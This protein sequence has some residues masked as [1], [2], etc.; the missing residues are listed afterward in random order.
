MK[1]SRSSSWRSSRRGSC[2]PDPH[3]SCP[4][5]IAC[6]RDDR[7]WYHV[8]QAGSPCSDRY[9]AVEPHYNGLARVKRSGGCGGWAVVDESGLVVAELGESVR[10]SAAHLEGVSKLY[11]QSLALKQILETD[12]L[13]GGCE[14][15]QRQVLRNV[16]VDMGLLKPPT[17]SAGDHTGD[18]CAGAD[19]LELLQRGELLGDCVT[20]ARCRYWLQ[21]R[22]LG[23]WLSDTACSASAS[24]AS[25]ASASS[26]SASSASASSASSASAS[27]ASASAP[28]AACAPQLDTFRSIA[29]DAVAVALSQRVL[30]SYAETDW[31]HI[32]EHLPRE[33]LRG[34][35]A[36]ADLGGGQGALLR[37]LAPLLP[38]PSVRLICLERPEVVQAAQA[39]SAEW[40]G[41]SFEPGDLFSGPLPAAD[42]YVMSRVLHDWDDTRAKKILRRVRS[43]CGS[44]SRLVVVDRAAGENLH[45]LL[46]LHMYHLQR[47]C[48]RTEAQWAELF[49]DT[50]WEV[51]QQTPLGEHLIYTLRAGAHG[52]TSCDPDISAARVAPTP[53]V[54]HVV[55]PTPRVAHVEAGSI[56]R[57]TKA[58]I[59]IAGLGSRMHPVSATTPKAF[60]PLFLDGRSGAAVVPALAVLLDQIFAPGGIERACVVASPA[61]LPQLHAF[62]GWYRP[63]L[64]A[65]QSV[66][67]AV[68]GS[69]RGMGD[70]C[71]AARQFV[72]ADAF[73][74]AVGDHVYSPGC[75]EQ[76]LRAHAALADHLSQAGQ[77]GQ[78][79]GQ[80]GAGDV[81]LTGACLCAESE[82]AATGLIAGQSPSPAVGEAFLVQ[83]MEEKPAAYAQFQL[84][85]HQGKYLSQLGL[86]ILP[87]SVFDALQEAL[88]TPSGELCLR[89]VVRDCLQAQ[90]RLYSVLVEGERHDI[91]TPAAYLDTLQRVYQASTLQGEHTADADTGGGARYMGV[92]GA[93]EGLLHAGGSR[94][95]A[96]VQHVLGAPTQAHV[97]SAPG[98]V[99][100][101]GGFADYSGS[102]AVVQTTAQRTAALATMTTPP[103]AGAG[104]LRL[105]T[106]QVRDLEASCPALISCRELTVPTSTLFH[107]GRLMQGAA[108]RD[109]LSRLVPQDECAWAYYLVG[110]IHQ[111]CAQSNVSMLPLLPHSDLSLVALSDLPWN[112]GLASSAAVTAAAALS[113]GRAMGLPE[114]LLA[115]RSTALL[116]QRVENDFVGAP[117]GILDQAG[118]TDPAAGAGL[119]GVD[120]SQRFSHPPTHGV[121]LP[122]GLAVVALESGVARCTRS[123]AYLQV[124]VAAEVGR[125]L[126]GDLLA[127]EVRELCEVAPSE[128]ASVSDHLPVAAT[129]AKLLTLMARSQAASP[130]LL[131][132][133]ATYPVRSATAHPIH[134][135]FRVVALEAALQ[136]PHTHS[137]AALD[138]LGELMR[139]SH[140]SYSLCGLGTEQTSLLVHLLTHTHSVDGSNRVVGAKLSGG[141]GG[142]AVVALVQNL[143]LPDAH[144]S[145]KA[146]SRQDCF[147]RRVQGQYEQRTGLSCVLRAGSSP[148]A[149]YYPNQHRAYSCK[150]PVN[151]PAPERPS[152]HD[153]LSPPG[154]PWPRR[155]LVVNHGYPPDFNGGSEVYAQTLALQLRKA[156]GPDSVR[157]FAR[158]CDPFRCDF[159]VRRGADPIDPGLPVYRMNYPREAPYFRFSAAP[160]DEAFRTVLEE[161]QPDV[162]H[163]HHLNHLSLGLP[164]VAKESG[165]AVVYTLHDYWLLCPRGQF[166]VTGVTA[167]ATE[168]GRPAEPWRQCGGQGDRKCAVSCY[169]G[170]YATG[171]GDGYGCTDRRGEV[172]GLPAKRPLAEVAPD[173]SLSLSLSAAEEDYWTRWI[174]Q[175]MAATRQACSHVDA[176]LA[177]SR[178]LFDKFEQQPDAIDAAKMRLMPYGFDRA[179]LS[180]RQRP[181]LES[182]AVTAPF[183]FAYIGRHLPA[184]G[185]NLLV[186][187]ALLL[188]G[189]PSFKQRFV[190]KIF[191]PQE[192]HSTRALRR[193]ADEVDEAPGSGRLQWEGEYANADIVPRVF[194]Q[195]DCIVVPSIWEENSPLVI[196]EALQS[197]VPVITA[198]SGGM[199]E[200][201]KDG[202]NGLT[203]EHRSAPSLAG[204][205]QRA[206]EQPRGLQTLA[207]RGY[208]HSEDGQVPCIAQHVEQMLQ[209]YRALL[210][211]TAQAAPDA[212]PDS[213]ITPLP[214]PWRVTFD[215]NP[216]DCNF[217][218]TMCE[219]HSEHSPHQRARRA[220][221][222]RRRRMDVRTIRS[223]VR[224]LAPRGLREIIPTTMGEPLQY[225][226]LPEMLDLCREF[227]VKLNLTTNGSF[228]GRGVDAW[229][230]LIVPVASDVKFSWN[231]ATR[232]TQERIMKGADFHKQV[233]NLQRFVAI[234]DGEAGAGNYCSVTLQLT[235]M[236]A[237]LCE[238]PALVRFAV[239]RGCDRVKGHHLWA[240][241]EQIADQ[242]LRR[243]AGSVARWNSTAALC[244][245]VAAENPLPSGKLLRLQNFHDL[246]VTGGLDPA[247]PAEPA[248]GVQGAQGAQGGGAC[249]FLGREAWVNWQGRFDPC[250]APD[251]ERKSLGYLGN[252]T[253][254]GQSVSEIWSS[255]QYRQLV[256]S[257]TAHPL[258]RTC[259]MRKPAD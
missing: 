181:A 107:D 188:G 229:A 46:S 238:L 166:S 157:V 104:T 176:F 240:H 217:H 231:G 57:V 77:A 216:D 186:Q 90:G 149:R 235:F 92:L 228:H 220:Q 136:A 131:D 86:D 105:A 191:G 223:V 190:V 101:M 141:G 256:S 227:G 225:A 35:T 98:R 143:R 221:G 158:E 34:V 259:T 164:G 72:G 219:Q 178:H 49:A 146:G 140:Q 44:D 230:R 56:P 145:S 212:H 197:G 134:E 208:L 19:G 177:P 127:R 159:E 154:P 232:E 73:L 209:L 211:S 83:H 84:S 63:T 250:C 254:P 171:V 69:P 9:A 142:G 75:V 249:P 103:G 210:P 206:L 1:S 236:E 182:Q 155:V 215:T 160:V 202:V 79:E 195:V 144:R 87:A 16:A 194:D 122:A 156:M 33:L 42:V 180:G 203:F 18:H 54:A 81:G 252:V 124:R 185:I 15:R 108:V 125:V 213:S 128:F 45:S 245:Q 21:D 48:E 161:W 93:V 120:C 184:K 147:W 62:L 150:V 94:V 67:V 30:A 40:G 241:F 247:E 100:L 82:I 24:S 243:S 37:A 31:Q 97:A 71:L 173:L 6:V 170:R 183:V 129:G 4:L 174:S 169:T 99:D 172:A 2:A 23:A 58:V 168:G 162:V 138:T 115:P 38:D 192:G 253:V 119:V 189:D 139:Q 218:C 167:P 53:R 20:A 255:P 110:A 8:D 76:F 88:C 22:Y 118:I 91:G 74:L 59:P 13:K 39:Q 153:E 109:R 179:R 199:G 132:P 65:A 175:R 60:L 148:G 14:G 237:N 3:L 7:G 12:L 222:V 36:I 47:S 68:Q 102:R 89:S 17:A 121:Q 66:S 25:S 26:A 205:M 135:R 133:A 214:S 239:E 165:A 111:L 204:A 116:C 196:L 80:E 152:D 123:S 257:Y 130:F 201:V 5:G 11:W 95:P 258:C 226:G 126:L 70:A 64:S 78:G 198:Q 32:A 163:F 41:V 28:S 112:A 187:A 246:P 200:L 61:Q 234:R 113:V 137:Q 27:S 248:Q 244:R 10:E 29:A 251:A 55:A 114:A 96:A 106:V 242:D 85:P 193:L 207:Q 51:Q 151:G 50:G 117:C 224:E 52:D 233:Q 43:C